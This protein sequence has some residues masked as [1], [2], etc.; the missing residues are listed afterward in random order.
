MHHPPGSTSD[1]AAAD[2]ENT[3]AFRGRN[4]LRLPAWA[5]DASLLPDDGDITVRYDAPLDAAEGAAGR[6]KPHLRI[7]LTAYSMEPD[8]RPERGVGWQWALDL[9]AA[10]HEVWV[11]TSARN[12]GAIERALAAQ[13]VTNLHFIYH[14]LPAWARVW[15]RWKRAV[16]AFSP[17]WTWGAHRVARGLC[18]RVAFDAGFEVKNSRVDAALRI[19]KLEGSRD[20]APR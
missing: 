17:L 18:R 15:N 5:G 10:G 7:L 8:A 12:A 4:A 1:P 2:G 16:R 6:R 13:R 20:K 3:P 11:I 9:A 14:D 19:M